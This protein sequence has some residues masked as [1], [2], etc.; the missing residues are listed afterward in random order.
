MLF[1][2]LSGKSR[3]TK[4]LFFLTFLSLAFSCLSSS[5][6]QAEQ[7]GHIYGW[8]KSKLPNETLTNISKIAA[9]R[10]HS[11]ALKSDGSIVGWGGDDYGQATPPTGNDFIAI[12]LGAGYSLALKSDGS[13]VGWGNNDY[14]Q[15][16]PPDGDDFIAIAAAVNTYVRLKE[17]NNLF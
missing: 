14:G 7:Q 8:G 4:R 15:A 3:F 6:V 16:T 9:G 2:S 10:R 11:L 17:N 5:A 13:I 12:A 1:K